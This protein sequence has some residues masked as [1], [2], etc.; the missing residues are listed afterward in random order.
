MEHIRSTGEATGGPPPFA[1]SNR[2]QFL[3]AL[4]QAIARERRRRAEKREA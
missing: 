3:Q 1:P 2:S 4:D